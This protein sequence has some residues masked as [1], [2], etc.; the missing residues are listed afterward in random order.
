MINLL[1]SAATVRRVVAGEIFDRFAA[2]RMPIPPKPIGA[3]DAD[4]KLGKEPA[5]DP[6]GPMRIEHADKKELGQEPATD[7]P[8]TM[9]IEH[10]D[11]KE[12]G[13]EPATDPSGATRIE[14][15]RRLAEPLKRDVA[16]EAK[17]EQRNHR[18]KKS[19]SPGVLATGPV[20]GALS[21]PFPPPPVFRSRRPSGLLVCSYR[22]GLAAPLLT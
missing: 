16:I 7:P 9:R 11:E 20:G 4:K 12:L 8:R 22:R 1:P 18:Q 5:T 19:R 13:Q 15:A 2:A 17:V 14:R 3:G 21:L 6:S 10:A